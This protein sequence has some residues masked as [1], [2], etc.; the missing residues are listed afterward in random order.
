M[1]RRDLLKG[2]LGAAGL[3]AISGPALA[4]ATA[5]RALSLVNLHTGE[6]LKAIYWEAGKY[7]PD[8][9]AALNRVLRDHRTG[10]VYDMAPGLLDLVASL[11]DKLDTKQT[12]QVISGYRSPKTNAALHAQ[13]NGVAT[14]SLHMKGEAMDIRIAGVELSRLR[15]AALSLQRGGVG[16]YPGSNFVH[17]DIGRVRRW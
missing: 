14:R 5:P 6:A 17:V 3:S 9:M 11:T 2:A 4:A 13:S 10:E 16:F 7:V 1:H 12:V 8:A 15:D